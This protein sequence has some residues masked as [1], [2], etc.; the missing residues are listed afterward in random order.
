MSPIRTLSLL[1][2]ATAIVAGCSTPTS[3]TGAS[4]PELQ[5][6]AFNSDTLTDTTS[7]RSGYQVGQG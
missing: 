4:S 3:P 1:L 5:G 7:S 2:A 6:P